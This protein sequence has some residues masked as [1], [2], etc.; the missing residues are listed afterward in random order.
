MAAMGNHRYLIDKLAETYVDRRFYCP[1]CCFVPGFTWAA[2]PNPLAAEPAGT[3]FLHWTC[4]MHTHGPY[5]NT[6]MEEEERFFV[7]IDCGSH[8]CYLCHGLGGTTVSCALYTED[9]WDADNENTRFGIVGDIQDWE[10]GLYY[11]WGGASTHLSDGG[12]TAGESDDRDLQPD[13]PLPAYG[14]NLDRSWPQSRL[15]DSYPH[16]TEDKAYT[17]REHWHREI[18]QLAS[19][20]TMPAMPTESEP[21]DSPASSCS[22]SSWAARLNRMSETRIW[23]RCARCSTGTCAGCL[24]YEEDVIKPGRKRGRRTDPEY[25]SCSG[26]CRRRFCDTCL[27]TRGGDAEDWVCGGGGGGGEAEIYTMMV[28]T[29]MTGAGGRGESAPCGA[30]LC[31][32]CQEVSGLI[33]PSV[34]VVDRDFEEAVGEAVGEARRCGE[35]KGVWICPRCELGMPLQ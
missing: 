34:G 7:C 2:R 30:C 22:D 32:E 20:H 35:R 28:M 19:A 18:P 9:G 15:F 12:D 6:C 10:H 29:G 8:M 21:A 26:S 27:N 31:L 13:S 14:T 5:C 4:A 11:G 33:A 3:K 24:G 17:D 23:E 16:S 1:A 25:R